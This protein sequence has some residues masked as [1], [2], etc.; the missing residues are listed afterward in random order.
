MAKVVIAICTI[1]QIGC[2]VLAFIGKLTGDYVLSSSIFNGAI[3]GVVGSFQLTN[4]YTTGKAADNNL[5]TQ[6]QADQI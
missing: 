1:N 2:F 4:A 3:F 6:A 5:L